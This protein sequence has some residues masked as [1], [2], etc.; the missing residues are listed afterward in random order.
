MIS[1]AGKQIEFNP[2]FRMFLCTRNEQI[3]MPICTRSLLSEVNFTTTKSGL[4]SQLLGLAI[5]LEKP[6]LEERSSALAR[7]SES[8]KLELEKLE[9]LLLQV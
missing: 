9:Q 3:R 7:D 1:F 2:E 8:K 5:Q 6:E 4:S